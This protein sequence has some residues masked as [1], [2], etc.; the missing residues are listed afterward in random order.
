MF[1]P[2]PATEVFIDVNVRPQTAEGGGFYGFSELQIWATGDLIITNTGFGC[3]ATSCLFTPFPFVLG[4]SVKATA[5]DDL[6]GSFA[7]SE[8]VLSFSV[9]GTNGYVVV[10]SGEYIDATGPGGDPGDPQTITSLPLV[11]VP[12][13]SLLSLL[14]PGLASLASL[15][16]RRRRA[17]RPTTAG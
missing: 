2:S 10:T 13:P 6:A 3:Q 7:A 14:L 9:S 17:T 11:Q 1:L 15:S 12:E 8:D 4:R 5:G 16:T